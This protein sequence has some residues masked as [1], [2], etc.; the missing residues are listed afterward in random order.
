VVPPTALTSMQSLALLLESWSSPRALSIV[1][2]AYAA[3]VVSSLTVST[4]PDK[5]STSQNRM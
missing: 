1:P 5:S 3:D 2:P 4:F